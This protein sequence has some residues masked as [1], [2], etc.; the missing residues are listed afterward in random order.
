MRAHPED[1]RLPT[2]STRDV[3]GAFPQRT[4]VRLH[5]AARVCNSHGRKQPNV[6]QQQE[7]FKKWFDLRAMEM[8]QQ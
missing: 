2:R 5:T 4:Q 6:R 7:G 3:H 1:R 8:T